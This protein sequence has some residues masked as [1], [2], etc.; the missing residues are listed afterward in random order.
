LFEALPDAM[1][2]V[3]QTGTIVLV[4]TQM[5]RLFGYERDEPLG[6]PV[7]ILVPERLRNSHRGHRASYFLA[8]TVRPMGSVTLF[9]RFRKFP[10]PWAPH[11]CRALRSPGHKGCSIA[12]IH[13]P[14]HARWE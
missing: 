13:V 10:R 7:D 4:N 3:D 5:E 11:A 9:A 2:V 14:H 1:V 6:K 8:P 12:C